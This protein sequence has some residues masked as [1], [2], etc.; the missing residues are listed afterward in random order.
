MLDL[1]DNSYSTVQY[2]LQY[3]M[4][5][6]VQYIDTVD[7]R[8]IDCNSHNMSKLLLPVSIINYQQSTT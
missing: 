7:R 8:M 5:S 3:S 2:V 1:V 4:Y 6:T